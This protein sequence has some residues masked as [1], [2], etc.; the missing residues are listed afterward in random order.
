MVVPTVIASS[1]ALGGLIYAFSGRRR[2]YLFL[3]PLGLPMSA[4]A[5]LFIK[6]PLVMAVAGKAGVSPHIS[7]RQPLW[8]LLFALFVAPFVE[9]AIK[10]LPLASGRVRRLAVVGGGALWVGM[11]LGV[12]YG[13]GECIYLA[14]ASAGDPRYVNLPWY[15]F[16]GFLSGR[17]VACFLHGVM[18]AVVV[19]MWQRGVAWAFVGYLAAV[20]LH[21]LA[22]IGAILFQLHLVPGAI[23]GL[24]LIPALVAT[25]WVFE[26]MRRRMGVERG[27][28][29][30]EVLYWSSRE[31]RS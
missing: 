8:F 12:G 25:T 31:R 24:M 10:V 3:I 18:T 26:H 22:D 27:E 17:L 14:V 13:L 1:L 9:E 6:R 21:T 19:V 2:P 20:G 30:T 7:S 29:G 15:A 23:A 16:T 28:G 5:N 4:L 11:A